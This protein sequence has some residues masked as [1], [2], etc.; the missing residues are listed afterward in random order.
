[1]ST[2]V[3]PQLVANNWHEVLHQDNFAIG[4][5]VSGTEARLP[6]E[7]FHVDVGS[8]PVLASA[9]GSIGGGD[10]SSS[11]LGSA[12][13]DESCETANE[14]VQ[15]NCP[16]SAS[17]RSEPIAIEID[18]EAIRA[19]LPLFMKADFYDIAGDDEVFANSLLGDPMCEWTDSHRNWMQQFWRSG[20]LG[21]FL[22]SHATDS[23]LGCGT[24]SI[25]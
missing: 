23:P 19:R 21:K 8:D 16:A 22:R 10:A 11:P 15:C 2:Q 12:G 25:T 20:S 7:A 9:D 1:M 24:T 14:D 17:D 13:C 18:F 4:L 5:T 6:P 3:T